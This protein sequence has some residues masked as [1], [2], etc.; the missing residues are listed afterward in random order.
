MAI[1]PEEIST[2]TSNLIPTGHSL[3]RPQAYHEGWQAL[4]PQDKYNHH[5]LLWKISQS[6]NDT[7]SM[8]KGAIAASEAT[9]LS[10][11]H[12]DLTVDPLHINHRGLFVQN[13]FAISYKSLSDLCEGDPLSSESSTENKKVTN[14]PRN[15]PIF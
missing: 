15:N 9:I 2:K 5:V 3:V 4:S 11:E 13:L 1:T 14:L 8:Y 10:L 6:Y 12:E 7:S